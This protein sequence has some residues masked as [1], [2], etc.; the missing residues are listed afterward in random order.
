ML[1]DVLWGAHVLRM[2]SG[3]AHGVK[4]RRLPAKGYTG[5]YVVSSF[6]KLGDPN[7]DPNIL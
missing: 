3:L 1:K 7:I 4:S 6:P 5:F 2:N